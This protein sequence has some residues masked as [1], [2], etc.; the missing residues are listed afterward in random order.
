MR[1]PV[2]LSCLLAV[3]GHALVGTSPN[4]KIVEEALEFMGISKSDLVSPGSAEG[5]KL[6]R[7]PAG[8]VAR[9]SVADPAYWSECICTD[10]M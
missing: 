8:H 7:L 2:Y 5:S 1:L 10:V 4:S 6:K 9:Q 3:G